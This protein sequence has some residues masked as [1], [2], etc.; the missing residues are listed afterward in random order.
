MRELIFIQEKFIEESILHHIL[1]YAFTLALISHKSNENCFNFLE[2]SY[3][4][5]LKAS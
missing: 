3:F 1:L 2:R 5:F 4:F